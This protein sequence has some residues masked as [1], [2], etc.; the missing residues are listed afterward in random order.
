VAENSEHSRYSGPN[1]ERGYRENLLVRDEGATASVE[2]RFPLRKLESQGGVERWDPA[3]QLAVYA[4]YGWSKDEDESF[5]SGTATEI[6]SVVAGVLWQPLDG[7]GVE[8]YYGISLNDLGIEGD[9]PQDD[10]I[11]LA[12]SYSFSR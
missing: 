3:L 1:L 8:F 2:W 6:Y 7:M 4:D 9:D 10:G 5:T 12:V 11:H